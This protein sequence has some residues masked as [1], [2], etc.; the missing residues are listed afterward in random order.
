MSCQNNIG[1][2]IV[3]Y[4]TPDLVIKCVNSILRY[5]IARPQDIIIV[6]NASSDESLPKL[7]AC[8]PGTRLIPSRIN[9]GFG[10]GINEGVKASQNGTLMILNPD[11]YFEDDSIRLAIRVLENDPNIAI[12]GLDLL[13]PDGVRQ[14]PSRRFYSML[15][16]IARRTPLGR[17]WPLKRRVDKHLMVDSWQ[18]GHPFPVEWVMGTGFLIRRHVFDS[19]GG[20]DESYFL[21]MEDVDLCARVWQ[22]GYKVYCVPNARLIHD[23]KR[24][25]ASVF[26]NSA[27]RM[28]IQA[29]LKFRKK[30]RVPILRPPNIRTLFRS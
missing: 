15:D 21:Y 17:C 6:D 28:H 3:N 1:V 25:S 2:I 7:A 26:L 8:L 20:M 11:T 29:F 12:V 27:S 24:E 23:H 19:V 10:A 16:I 14:Y 9:A 18:A 5:G 30:F 4:R 22:A 13:Y